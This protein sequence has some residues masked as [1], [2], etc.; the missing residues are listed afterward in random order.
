MEMALREAMDRKGVANMS[1]LA[2][3]KKK[4]KN[5]EANQELETIFSRTLKTRGPK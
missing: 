1:T 2:E 3:K 4:R 5:P